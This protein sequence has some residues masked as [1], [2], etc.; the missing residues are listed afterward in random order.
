MRSGADTQE[1][2][3]VM[4]VVVVVVVV[5]TAKCWMAQTHL[6]TASSRCDGW[7]AGSS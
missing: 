7:S 5:G 4:V 6:L 2:V 1:V 3:V